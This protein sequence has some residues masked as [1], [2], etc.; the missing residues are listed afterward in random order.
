[1]EKYPHNYRGIII[2]NDDPEQMGRVK[3][4]V[5]Q[6]NMNIYEGWTKDRTKDKKF[7]NLGSN[8]N[9]DINPV[10]LQRLREA[11]P[12]AQ[13]QYPVFGMGTSITYN[14]DID[15]GEKANDSDASNQHQIINKA[16][17]ESKFTPSLSATL[18][19]GFDAARTTTKPIAQETPQP[20]LPDYIANSTSDVAQATVTQTALPVVDDNIARLDIEYILP[21]GRQYPG[22]GGPP[23]TYGNPVYQSTPKTFV[24]VTFTPIT[25]GRIKRRSFTASSELLVYKNVAI[26]SADINL[27]NA[28]AAR[29][30]KNTHI[31]I[32]LEDIQSLTI[33]PNNPEIPVN[34][35]SLRLGGL[36]PL[37]ASYKNIP[38]GPTSTPIVPPSVIPTPTY[39]SG[40]SGSA[41]NTLAMSNLLPFDGL[42][43][44]IIGGSNPSSVITSTKGVA[45]DTQTDPLETKYPNTQTPVLIDVPLRSGSQGDKV[46][47]MISIPSVG[48]HVSVY[49][50][51]GDYM[52]PIINGVFYNQEDFKGIHDVSAS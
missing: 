16:L 2:Q 18:K 34:L 29:T 30:I 4:W 11:L 31:S 51:N 10:I 39:N 13:I 38:S 45:P 46:K 8:L 27:T 17:P 22:I 35:T 12:W 50:E 21:S 33:I 48:S 37:L 20:T 23:V 42:K 14:A 25:S 43:K 47:G 28:T 3:V 32:N 7:T 52:F 44:S 19:A 26:V 1:M 9:S 6:V 15:Y 41:M 5:P 49:F 36:Q 24:E 40:G